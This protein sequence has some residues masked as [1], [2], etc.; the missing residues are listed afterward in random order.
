[1][2]AEITPYKGRIIFNLKVK[3]SIKNEV[4]TKLDHTT[5]LSHIIIN[6]KKNLGISKEALALLQKVAKTNKN[7]GDLDWS[8]SH[9]GLDSF[10]WVGSAQDI[11]APHDVLAAKTYKIMTHVTI[12][13]NVPEGAVEAI[14][15]I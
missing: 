13:N 8:K 1:M 4:L 10:L 7:L 14:D 3:N 6:T 15:K 9:N 2:H 11:K 5:P 12:D